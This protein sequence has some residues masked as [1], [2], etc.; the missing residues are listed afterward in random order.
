M[1][2]WGQGVVTHTQESGKWTLGEV[3][4]DKPTFSLRKHGLCGGFGL[5]M[6]CLRLAEKLTLPGEAC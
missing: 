3:T 2:S 5:R 6:S 1:G 4:L